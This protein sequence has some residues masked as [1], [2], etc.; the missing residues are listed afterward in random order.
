VLVKTSNKGSGDI[1]DLMVGDKTIYETVGGLVSQWGSGLI[2]K[3][4]FSSVGAVVGATHPVQ[5]EK[6]RAVM[7]NTFFLIPGYGAQGGTAQDLAVCFN[8]KGLGGIV[9]SSRGI[10]GAYKMP[11]YGEFGE[12]DHAKAARQAALDMKADLLSCIKL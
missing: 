12:K 2:G 4:G 5:A 10:T 6:S 3:H 9:N 7:P 8:E 1:Q 11:R